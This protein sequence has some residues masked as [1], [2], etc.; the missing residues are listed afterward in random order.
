MDAVLLF[1]ESS[2]MDTSSYLQLPLYY[3]CSRTHDLSLSVQ[4]N[5]NMIAARTRLHLI[6]S[7][8]K[9]LPRNI[10][11]MCQDSEDVEEAVIVVVPLQWAHAVALGQDTG[12]IGRDQRLRKEG[13]GWRGGAVDGAVDSGH[14]GDGV[15]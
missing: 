11:H 10:A 1:S 5:Q 3:Q 2:N 12:D 13:V 4:D 15:I 7:G 8:L 6:K 9:L 14:V